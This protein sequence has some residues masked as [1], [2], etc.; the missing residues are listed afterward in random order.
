[1]FHVQKITTT[2][3]FEWSCYLAIFVIKPE[4]VNCA[5]TSHYG[6]LYPHVSEYHRVPALFTSLNNKL[7]D[8]YTA[9]YWPT[10]SS[11]YYCRFSGGGDLYVKTLVE[12]PLVIT[13]GGNEEQCT[14]E[15]TTEEQPTVEMQSTASTS[16]AGNFISTN[17]GASKLATLIVE[18]KRD[19]ASHK[20]P[21]E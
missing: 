11:D 1:M 12:P 15:E 3:I 20:K 16:S 17:T 21:T 13:D 10:S 6:T 4:M 7:E 5:A 18:G 19:V 2:A 8:K 14:D 9:A